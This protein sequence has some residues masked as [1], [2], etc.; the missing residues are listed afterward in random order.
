MGQRI[1]ILI[2]TFIIGALLAMT[3]GYYTEYDWS[4][5]QTNN[6]ETK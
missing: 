1:K 6:G 2:A 3:A 5:E 4:L